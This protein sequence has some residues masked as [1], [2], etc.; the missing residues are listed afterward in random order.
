MLENIKLCGY[1]R[2][3]PVQAYT[4]PAVLNGRDIIS[5]AQT[6]KL[7]HLVVGASLTSLRLGQD[8]SVPDSHYLQAYG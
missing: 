4:I 7:F 3:T 2:P 6:G 1:E 5:I 8:C